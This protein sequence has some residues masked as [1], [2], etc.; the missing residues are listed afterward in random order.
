MDVSQVQTNRQDAYLSTGWKHIPCTLSMMCKKII[1]KIQ[2]SGK[3]YLLFKL[4]TS[5]GMEEMFFTVNFYWF[6]NALEVVILF[7][8]DIE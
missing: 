5:L 4:R 8:V 7:A 2:V 1:G 6:L 3:M